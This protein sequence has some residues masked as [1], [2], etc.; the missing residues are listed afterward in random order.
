MHGNISPNRVGLFLIGL[1][2]SG[3]SVPSLVQP[4]QLAL[5]DFDVRV[6]RAPQDSGLGVGQQAAMATLARRVPTLAADLD[7]IVGVPRWVRSAEGYLLG[8]EA[9]AE[10]DPVRRADELEADPHRV[11]K[12]FLNEHAALYGHDARALAEARLEQDYVTPHNGLRTVVWQQQVGGIRILD[13]TLVAHVT[14]NG[15]LVAVSSGLVGNPVAALAAHQPGRTSPGAPPVDAGRAIALAAGNLGDDVPA[16]SLLEHDRAPTGAWKRRHFRSAHLPAEAGAELVALPWGPQSLEL[17]WEVTLTGTLH[18]ERY[19]VLIHATSG[20]VLG[21]WCITY[22]ASSASYQVYDRDSPSP[23]SPG[24]GEPSTYQP[25]ILD[26]ALV[27]WPALSLT[28]SPGG[29]IPDGDN[30]T[31]G[32]NVDA[33]CDW[34]NANV[35]YGGTIHRPAG[36]NRVFDFPLDLGRPPHSYSNA[37]VVNLFFWCNYVHDTLYDLGFTEAAGNY[38]QDN[39]GRG[40]VGND[41]IIAEAQDGWL[42]GRF[43]NANFTPDYAADGTPGRIQM[44][45]WNGPQYGMPAEPWRDGDLDAEVICHEYVHGMTVRLVSKGSLMWGLQTL[46]LNEGWS[47]FF[48]ISLL[49]Q[50]LDD[51]RGNYPAGAYIYYQRTNQFA[52]NY[53]FGARRYPYSTDLSKNPLTLVDISTHANPHP[54]IPRHPLVGVTLS[55][56]PTEVHNAGEVWCMMLLECR[57]RLIERYRAELDDLIEGYT[58]G[59][60]TMMQLVVDGMRLAPKHPKFPE[61]R[62]AILLADRVNHGGK[63]LDDLWAAFA[64]RGLGYGAIT[65][66]D[67]NNTNNWPIVESYV[68]PPRGA[69]KWQYATGNAIN[70]SP[71]LAWDGTETATLFVGSSDRKLHAVDARTGAKRW[72][73]AGDSGTWSFNSSPAVGTDGTVYVGCNDWRVYAITN[74]VKR[75]SCY[76]AGEVFSSPAIGD[77]GTVYVGVAAGSGRPNVWAF[78]P[79]GTVRWTYACGNT[80]YASPAIAADDTVYVTATDQKLYALRNG[81]QEWAYLLGGWGYSSPALGADGAIYVGAFDGKLYCLN[82]NGTLRWSYDTGAAIYSSPSVGTDGAVYVGSDSYRLYCLNPN[83]TLRWSYNTGYQVRSSPALGADDTVFVGGQNG[84]VHAI[85]NGALRWRYYT[86]GAVFSSPTLA[87]DGTLYVGAGNGKLY[88]LSNLTA[89]ASAPWPMFRQCQVHR[90]SWPTRARYRRGDTVTRGNWRGV[91]QD[92]Y[93]YGSEGYQIVGAQAVD[94]GPAAV[95]PDYARV[96]PVN[97]RERVWGTGMTDLRALRT[98]PTQWSRIAAGWHP[99]AGETFSVALELTDGQPHEV[100][101]YLLDW[102]NA[103]RAEYV[104]VRDAASGTLL[105]RVHA[106]AFGGGLYLTFQMKGRLRVD[107]T[108]DTGPD[109]VLSGLFFDGSYP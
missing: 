63:H 58:T 39:F 97:V 45:L 107:V 94:G 27:T 70:S 47:D 7:P 53:Y 30:R 37:A 22:Q 10:V 60:R 78:H 69:A 6:G 44:Y 75:W 40:G 91:Y 102:D 41:T 96:Q 48:A 31:L 106:P 109:P 108:R 54:G 105:E 101:F 29:W 17:C 103:G 36:P 4:R 81:I 88:A 99:F 92:Q 83:G 5:P 85:R 34:D 59:N 57:A 64:K 16:E 98:G 12:R 20:Q 3:C 46:A 23:L 32:N 21:R 56:S 9:E 67:L 15:E 87:R 24:L 49:G 33:R 18:P 90:G 11:L 71:A 61:A 72:E 62:D 13:A 50:P 100:S 66:T 55:S 93:V 95:Y 51:V 1:T 65:P 80:V 28:A 84:Y 38:Q 82:P 73:F 74:G 42:R 77:D 8:G 104:H 14:Q 19:V 86:G 26:R 52:A 43:N 25:P 68:T 79:D 2:L 89:T 35:P 76:V